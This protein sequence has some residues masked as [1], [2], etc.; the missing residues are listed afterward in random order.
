[1]TEKKLY[2][3]TAIYKWKNRFK[4]L[5]NGHKPKNVLVVKLDEI[6]DMVTSVHVFD[7]LKNAYPSAKID[8][9]CKP[10]TASLL[11]NQKSIHAVYHNL[12]NINDSYDTFIELRGNKESYERIRK[13]KPKIYLDR[14]SIRLANKITGGQKHEIETNKQIISSVC[15]QEILNETEPM[16]HIGLQDEKIASEFLAKNQLEDFTIFHI[17][18]GDENRRWGHQNFSEIANWLSQEFNQ[19]IVFVGAPDDLELVQKCRENIHVQTYS[20]IGQGGLLAFASLCEEANL[21]LGN[22]SGPMHIADIMKTPLLALFGP[23]VKN[24]FYPR[25]KR[26]KI[27]HHFIGKDQAT[28]SMEKIQIEEV[29]KAILSLGILQKHS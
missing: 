6:G 2:L 27:I 3:I 13:L 9:I 24:V 15:S 28:K 4:R 10:I 17:G 5:W 20:F 18:A 11:K 12:E 29:E 21:F 23:G 16:L 26:A 19:K 25:N 14:G 8:V 1:M 7:A 22:E